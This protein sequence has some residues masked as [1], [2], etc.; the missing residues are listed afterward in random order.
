MLQSDTHNQFCLAEIMLA[1]AGIHVLVIE[2]VGDGVH[3]MVNTS[4]GMSTRRQQK[5]IVPAVMMA[6]ILAGC[7]T[8]TS[9]TTAAVA[10]R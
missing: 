5:S 10:P 7:W 3:H 1:I 6:G 2:R 8:G 4:V 9:H